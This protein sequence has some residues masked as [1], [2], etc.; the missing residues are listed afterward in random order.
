MENK[1]FQVE[2]KNFEFPR[3]NQGFM[4]SFSNS[5]PMYVVAKDYNQA[6]HKASLKIETL[7]KEQKENTK[8]ESI[9]DE[10]G[11]LIRNKPMFEE[12]PKII[13]IRLIEDIV[14]W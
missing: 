6:F 7:V 10:D 5:V 12:E 14:V 11:S 1:L 2:I 8:S 3:K 13:G 9:L 4:L